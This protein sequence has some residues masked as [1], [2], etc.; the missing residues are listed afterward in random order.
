MGLETAAIIGIAGLAISAG[1][2]GMSFGQAAKQKQAESSAKSKAEQS[3][4][5]AR[6]RLEV[7][8]MDALSINK[9][10]YERQREA[11]LSA[12]AQALE[13][14]REGSERG[15]AAMAGRVLAQQQEG[16][17][18]IRDTMNRD[19]FNLEA[20]SAEEDSR[21]RDVNTQ[22]DLG[23]ASGAQA[24]AAAAADARQIA[25]SQ[26]IQSSAQFAQQAIAMPDL[27]RQTKHTKQRNEFEKLGS[28]MSTMGMNEMKPIQMQP[29]AF[30]PTLNQ[31]STPVPPGVQQVQNPDGT[32]NFSGIANGAQ[33]NPFQLPIYYRQ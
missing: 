14:G 3:M 28:G 12:G 23:V 15:S 2:A 27:Y 17:G 21:L 33:M 4:A 18:Q 13:A 1:S 19:I 10:P 8:Y 5:D 32:F 29:N 6:K 31:M 24:A 30:A 11:M 9:E 7:N 22:L 16:Q 25:I 26:G 20:A